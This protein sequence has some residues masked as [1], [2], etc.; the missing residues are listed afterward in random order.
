[1]PFE[2]ASTGKIKTAS[3]IYGVLGKEGDVALTRAPALA[4]VETF[5][6]NAYVIGR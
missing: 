2:L 6:V 5:F 4:Q 3:C 1:M